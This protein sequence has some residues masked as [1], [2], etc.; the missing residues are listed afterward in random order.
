VT[1][2]VRVNPDGSGFAKSSFSD[3]PSGCVELHRDGN[4]IRDSKNATASPLR[5]PIDARDAL[6]RF[7][8]R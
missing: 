1:T 6:V 7:A 3:V 2:K 5:L 8:R 4:A